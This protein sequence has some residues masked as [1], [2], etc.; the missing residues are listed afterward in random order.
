MTVENVRHTL[1]AATLRKAG[2]LESASTGHVRW[3]AGESVS[4]STWIIES[5]LGAAVTL[6]WWTEGV[7]VGREIFVWASRP[8]F[9]RWGF[10]GCGRLVSQIYFIHGGVGCRRCSGLGYESQRRSHGLSTARRQLSRCGDVRRLSE[11]SLIL[12]SGIEMWHTPERLRPV[13]EFSPIR[14]PH[15]RYD[16]FQ[17]GASVIRE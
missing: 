5:G 15:K 8:D 9:R 14:E 7:Y 16:L 10:Q 13:I 2:V 17:E 12:F 11:A 1:D 4:F 6:L 3:P